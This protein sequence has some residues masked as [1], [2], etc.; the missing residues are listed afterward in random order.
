VLS[1]TQQESE[2]MKRK[3][4]LKQERG[5]LTDASKAIVA[6]ADSGEGRAF[7]DAEKATLQANKDRVAAIDKELAE[8][9][10]LAEQI[11]SEPSSAATVPAAVAPVSPEPEAKPRVEVKAPNAVKDPKRG[12]NDHKEFFGSVMKYGMTGR[13]D[14]RLKPLAAAGSDEQGVY[15][16]PYGGFLVPH[17]VAPGILSLAPEDDPLAGLVTRVTMSAPSIS[18]NA[19]VDKNHSTS[20]SG[21]LTVTRRPETVAGTSSRMAFEQVTLKANGEFGFAFATEEILAD[22]PQSFV[23]ILSAGFR[24]EFAAF[25]M[26]ERINGAGSGQ[27]LGFLQAA[28]KIEVAKE[29]GQPA[30][31][32]QK[33]NIDKMAARCWRYGR[34]VWIANHNTRVQLKGL[35]QVVGTGGNAVPYFVSSPDGNGATLDGRPIYFTEF[36]KTLG[37]AGDLILVVPSEYLEATYQGEQFAESMHVRF[38]EHERAFKFY[39]RTDRR[40]WWTSA[41]TPENGDTLSPIVT[42]A[43]RG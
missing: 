28:C 30:A 33:T 31:T 23:D 15:S 5:T 24:D 16:D 14:E 34:A 41:L 19:R 26:R 18:Y 2:A 11:R 43:T 40:P 35:V 37:T 6:A 25:A 1:S 7:T 39:R 22:S 17:G 20:V 36:A 27:G 32:I 42:L 10:A 38:S 12:F 8:I 29:T 9:E 4:A 3:L 21:G 13:M